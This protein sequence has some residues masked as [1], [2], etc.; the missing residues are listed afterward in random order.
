MMAFA[1]AIQMPPMMMVALAD[2]VMEVAAVAAIVVL[3]RMLVVLMLVPVP[4]NDW[5]QQQKQPI[6]DVTS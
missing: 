2:I 6:D 3:V 4:D 1:D 5:N